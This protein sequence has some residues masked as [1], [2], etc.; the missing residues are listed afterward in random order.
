MIPALTQIFK[1]AKMNRNLT[2]LGTGILVGFLIAFGGPAHADEIH[3]LAQ[4]GDLDGIKALIE[5]D[6]ELVDARDQDGRTALH[7]A[8]RG[9]HLDVVKYLVE[10]GANVDAED[11]NRVVP[12]HSLA[13]RNNAQGIAILVDKG[14]NV[15]AVSYGGNTALH[16][17]GMSDAANAVEILMAAGADLEIKEDYGRTP[18]ILCARERG[19]PKTIKLFLE[20]GADVDARDKFGASA[21]DLA[22][23]RGKKEVVDLLLDAGANIPS[24]GPHVFHLFTQASSQGLSRLF[25]EIVKAGVDPT[26][27]LGSGGTL[28]HEAAAGGSAEIIAILIDKGLDINLKDNYGWTPL[29][30]AARDGRLQA[31]EGLIAKGAD[32][33]ARTIMG[34]SPLNVA[35]ERKYGKVR[36][37]LIAKGA[38]DKPIQFPAL[39]GDYMGQTPPGE[40]PELFAPGI[41]SSIWGLHSAAAFSMDGNTVMWAPMITIPGALYST[42]G[43]LMSERINGRWTAP[44]FTEFTGDEEGD[45]PFFSPDGKRVYFMS[46]QDLPGVPK[47]GKERIWYVDCTAEG[48]SKPKPVDAAVNDYPHHWHFSVDADRTIYFSSSIPEGHGQGDIYCAKFVEGKWQEP[49]NL[50]SPVSTDQEEGM[51][52]IAPDGSYLLFSRT[53]DLYISYRNEDGGWSEP[54]NLGNPI[55]SPSIDICPMVSPDGKYLFFLSQRGGESHIWWVDAGFIEKLKR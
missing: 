19:G 28:L 10:K 1:G 14:A 29:H 35:I 49:R 15:D 55:N 9:V 21:L 39:E 3:E 2:I 52:F 12:L 8:C 22:A 43:I 34:Q 54:V 16:Y 26:F 33:D 51:P 45:V 44:C 30:Y 11:A 31:V 40:T 47:S 18:L 42:G 46:A 37:L 20:G 41:V 6:P 53:Y 4:K 36:D 38:D 5:K 50:D 13:T 24:K 7:W 17:A 23:W 25:G 27:K 48:W 32:I